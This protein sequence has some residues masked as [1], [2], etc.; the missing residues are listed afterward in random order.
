LIDHE[1]DGIDIEQGRKKSC[2]T[3][4]I[5][6]GLECWSQENFFEDIL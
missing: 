1:T 2:W 4:Q 6:E 3:G 5:V